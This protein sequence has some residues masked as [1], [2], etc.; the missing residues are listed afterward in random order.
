MKA[1]KRIVI[2]MAVMAAFM[3]IRPA[4]AQ[5]YGI[6]FGELEVT[7]ANANDIFGDGLAS[8]DVEQNRLVLQDG[9]E[10]H[11]SHG[12]VTINTGRAL[13]MELKGSV[14]LYA[15]IVVEDP[16]LTVEGEEGALLSIVSNISGS[17]L[18]CEDI[19]VMEGITLSLLSRNSQ[20][21][22]YALDC[23]T[24]TVNGSILEA[25]V[26]TAELAVATREM[27][28]N[29]CWLKK[30]RGGIVNEAWGGICYG[31]GAPAKIVNITTDGFGIDEIEEPAQH[32]E[33]IFKDG[34]ILI[35]KDGRRYDVTGREVR[36]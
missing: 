10:Y 8:Y 4:V 12:L 32:V 9:L 21:D 33:K 30:P 27:I 19:E 36:E 15:S 2:L 3:I 5:N 34:Q 22:M 7:E 20:S 35:I 1:M 23:K 17:A 25:E 13:K 28:L 31:D 18:Q 14:L 6:G 11:L 26:T 29:E 24:L 16:L